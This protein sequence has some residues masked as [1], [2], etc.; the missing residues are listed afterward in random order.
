MNCIVTAGPTFEPLDEVRRLTNFS[1]GKLGTEL[2]NFLAAR[3]H[4]VIL[5]VGEMATYSG[6]QKAQR[7]EF[8]STAADLRTKLKS[9]SSKKVDVIFHAAAVERF[10]VRQNFCAG[11][12]EQ[13]GGNQ[14][15]KKNPN[16]R[17]KI[18]GG[19]GADAKNHCRTARLVSE[20]Q[21]RRLE[22]RGG[23]QTRKRHRRRTKTNRGLR[24]GFM[25]RERPGL[26]RRFWTG[27]RQRQAGAFGESAV[28]V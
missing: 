8:F 27:R 9:F 3:G 16:A 7:E 6:E 22:I 1:T 10:F 14:I 24:D 20:N 17:R 25:C 28:V 4:K 23:R 5:L 19:I 2:A 21:N 26:R 18:A 11:R 13:I 15:G 12:G